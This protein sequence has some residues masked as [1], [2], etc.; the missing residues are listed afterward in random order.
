MGRPTLVDTNPYELYYHSINISMNRYN[1]SCNTV[2]DPRGKICDP[3]KME[4][5][6]LK[7]FNMIK[8][9]NKSKTLAIECRLFHLSV[10]VNLM[11][12]NVA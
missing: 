3:N 8:G 5:L 6:N 7:V 10:D 2:E 9:I 1:K 12:V 11:E 4:D